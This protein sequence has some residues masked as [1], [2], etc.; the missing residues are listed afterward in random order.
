MRAVH[1][2][3]GYA[4]LLGSVASHDDITRP[5]TSLHDY[6]E[7]TGTPPGRWFGR[8][9][10]GLG[11]TTLAQ[12]GV[13]EEFQMAALYGEGLHPDAEE[14]VKN[15]ALVKDTQLGRQYP[16]Y[17]KGVE[18]LEE[19]KKAEA[20]LKKQTGQLL[21]VKQ[22]SDLALQIARPFYERESGAHNAKPREILAWLNDQKNNVRQPVAGMDLTFSPAKSVSIA[23]A[24]GDD[25]TRQ[26]IQDI[27]TR[28]VKDALGYIEDNLL[29]TRTGAR[30]ERQIKAAGMLAATFVHY[31]TRAGEPD[32]HTHCLI[33]NK[34]QAAA[35]AGLS[36]Q[37]AATWRALD[38]RFLFKNSAKMSQL[39]NRMMTQRLSQE[40]GFAFRERVTEEGKASIW[41]I[42][43]ISDELIEQFS[44]R[45][46]NARP[47]YERYAA[48]YARTHGH[49]PSARARYQL[50]QQAILDTRDAKKKGQ[51]LKDHRETW[52]G[53]ADVQKIRA[54]IRAARDQRPYFPGHS[55]DDYRVCVEDLAREAVDGARQ[56]RAHFSPRHLDTE[57]SMRL[58]AWRF[59]TENIEDQVRHDAL[60]FAYEHLI[61]T[62]TDTPSAPLPRALLRDNGLTVDRDL[63][64]VVLTAHATLAEE[65]R[66]LDALD[67]LTGY[68]STRMDVDQALRDHAANTGFDLNRG[69]ELLVR[70]LVESGNQVTAGVGPAGT[71]KTAS[72]SVVADIWRSNGHNVIGLAPS[73]VAAENLSK[74]IK[75][76]GRTLASLT[77]RWRGI[78]GDRPH[79]V[80]ALGVDIAPGDMLLVD[81]AGMAT[82]ADLA[83]IVEIAQETGA[84]VRMVG[85]PYQLD[86]V[87]TGGLFRTIVKHDDSV[88][89]DQVMRMGSDDDQAR[90]GLLIRQGDATGLDLYARRDW[91]HGGQRSDMIDQA[92]RDHIADLDAGRSGIL[93][94]SRRA[95]VD[96][97]NT[98][99]QQS[100][101]ANDD[102]DVEGRF[103]DLG[104]GHRAWCGDTILA[105]KNTTINGVKILNGSRF[106]VVAIGDDGSVIARH[107]ERNQDVLIP[108]GYVRDHLQ[109]GYAAT[110]HRAQG[111]TVDVTRAVV[112]EETER[113]GLYVAL[114]RGK[115]Q[116]HVYVSTDIAIDL[117]SEDGHW[118]MSGDRA[119][120]TARDVLERIVARDTGQRSAID[121]Y[122]QLRTDADSPQRAAQLY[123]TAHDLLTSQW[124]RE[125]VEPHIRRV[126]DQALPVTIVDELDETTVERIATAV[127]DLSRHGIDYTAIDGVFD[128]L[129]GSRDVGAVIAHRLR[130]HVPEQSTNF[131][132]ALPPRFM[133]MDDELYQWAQATRADIVPAG[134]KLRELDYV[135]PEKGIVEGQDFSQVDF[136]GRDLSNLRFVDCDFTGAAFDNAVFHRTSFKQSTMVDSSFVGVRIGEGD[137][138]FKQTRWIGCDLSGA[139]FTDAHLERT[140]FATTGICGVDFSRAELKTVSFDGADLSDAIFDEAKISKEVRVLKAEL[141]ETAPQ[142][143]HDKLE[144]AREELFDALRAHDDEEQTPSSQYSLSEQHRS[145]NS[146]LEL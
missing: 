81:E 108:A 106:T 86:A 119:P 33:S 139:D 13:V 77:Y 146:G 121:I 141:S 88:E 32:L 126:L 101:I 55:D 117:E 56:R 18:V 38:T 125:I 103:V 69:Q 99:I 111:V 10:S 28:C 15:G 120:D 34:V 83:A 1:A 7:A 100:C 66:V 89:L 85:D 35:E 65:R 43:G 60:H 133:G 14:R 23:W 130:Q 25:D 48:D 76:D 134:H 70:H 104:T 29:F 143:L 136:R 64:S 79:D 54:T 42:E 118:H 91:I 132:P 21:T 37:D 16:T 5:E 30:S 80:T 129:E 8:G 2:G 92:V 67:E 128:G 124:R 107:S 59:S 39:Y 45:R 94:A 27:H 3:D 82:T 135:L 68:V 46:L 87:E 62:V 36:P 73:A 52:M 24:L 131:V 123:G 110:I 144:S 40:L 142:I 98:L 22:R 9:I 17:S 140:T 63:E 11:K 102:I 41:E 75:S 116:N 58:N 78:V 19:I 145:N 74:D 6:Y 50:W 96:I 51:S 138:A 12:D 31:D 97:A 137:S 72:M 47:V 84:V 95:D 53:Q 115:K 26:A 44:S 90:A 114:T 113:R 61:M 49:Q 122:Q 71:G 109:L 105:R 20:Q 127:V 57:L 4:Y 93:I 112:G